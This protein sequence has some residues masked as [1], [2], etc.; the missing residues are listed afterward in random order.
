MVVQI[1]RV[2]VRS[3]YR[4]IFVA[5]QPPHKLYANLMRFVGRSLSGRKALDYMV[6]LPS[7]DFA[8]SRFGRNHFG[9][10]VVGGAAIYYR[11]VQPLL[12]LIAVDYILYRTVKQCLFFV[13]DIGNVIIQTGIDCLNFCDSHRSD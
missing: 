13:G 9:V 6:A 1:I 2:K 7:A 12:G 5:E 4:L 10:G 8:P 3:D 11:F